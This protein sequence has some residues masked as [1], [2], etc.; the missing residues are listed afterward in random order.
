MQRPVF[1]IREIH[2]IKN[3]NDVTFPPRRMIKMIVKMS[4]K[5]VI[6]IG[7]MK[8]ILWNSGLKR[9]S[10]SLSSSSS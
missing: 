7:R 10:F 3:E 4:S 2:L 5:M 6:V 9:I 1:E 8:K